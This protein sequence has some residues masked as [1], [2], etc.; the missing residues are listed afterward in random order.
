MDP[1]NPILATPADIALNFDVY[2]TFKRVRRNED[3]L[4]EF[5]S[6]SQDEILYE[7]STALTGDFPIDAPAADFIDKLAID[8]FSPARYQHTIR[9]E[10]KTSDCYDIEET[11][12]YD[13]EF[14]RQ[15]FQIDIAN[16]FYLGEK[17]E[18]TLK[19]F[20]V[21][22]PGDMLTR[23]HIR[24]CVPP[25]PNNL[26]EEIDCSTTEPLLFDMTVNVSFNSLTM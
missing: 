20:I 6:D 4:I 12:I 23:L 19:N 8:F 1:A 14:D 9:L 25:F 24:Y 7:F 21:Q 15:V 13:F 18:F 10:S 22:N 26:E 17:L 16:R 2:H 11:F 5:H 3:E